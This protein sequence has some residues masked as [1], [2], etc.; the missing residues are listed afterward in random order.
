MAA[1]YSNA[2]HRSFNVVLMAAGFLSNSLIAG[3]Y[4]M[5]AQSFPIHLR[6]SG[7]GF[8]IGVGRYSDGAR[9]RW[10]FA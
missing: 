9:H 1:E 6:A 2:R 3:L 7:T 5:F 4:A 8:V 10:I